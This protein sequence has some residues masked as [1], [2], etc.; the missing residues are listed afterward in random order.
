M[1]IRDRRILCT[2]SGDSRFAEIQTMHRARASMVVCSKAMLNVARALA[3]RYDIPFFE[4]SFY[5]IENTSQAIRRFAALPA[6]PDLAQRAERLISLL[7][8]SRCV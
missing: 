5:G 7:Y 6:D 2:L 4:G 3:E 1:C 8:T